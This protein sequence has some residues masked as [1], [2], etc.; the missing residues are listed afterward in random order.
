MGMDRRK[1]IISITVGALLRA[2][3]LAQAPHQLN[4][5]YLA[6]FPSVERVM[7]EIQG[8]DAHESALRQEAALR[9]L[10]QLLEDAA[11]P[12][13]FRNQ[14]TPDEQKL[15]GEYGFAQRRLAQQLNYPMGGYVADPKFR[16][17]IFEHFGLKRALA[18]AENADAYYKAKQDARTAQ[19]QQQGAPAAGAAGQPAWV[20]DPTRI[21][22]RRCLELGGGL[23]E[24]LGRGMKAGI[25]GLLG[26]DTNAV[27]HAVH[28]KGIRMIGAYRGSGATLTFMEDTV[29][30]DNCS[31][32]V[33]LFDGYSV[34]RVGNELAIRIANQPQPIAARLRLDGHILAPAAA[35]VTGKMVVGYQNVA[36]SKRYADGS[37]VPG[38]AHMERRPISQLRMQHC[39]IGTLQPG[40]AAPPDKDM[41]G[42]TTDAVSLVFSMLSGPE[43]QKEAATH[44]Q[45]VAPGPRLAGIYRSHDGLQ[46]EFHSAGAVIDC[47]E[48]H[49][50]ASYVVSNTPGGLVIN[51]HNGATPVTLTLQGDGSLL[52]SG[53]VT[54]NGRLVAGTSGSDVVFRPVSRSCA[55]G[56]LT[57]E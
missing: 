51:V 33:D 50:A 19:Q 13:L 47:K 11:G 37:M 40:Q 39:V 45:L 32:L 57:A 24:C 7:A 41:I 46:I 48:A 29:S 18:Q 54:V 5:L 36:V 6:E 2:V 20:N 53:E 27:G 15:D 38:S 34:E 44:M 42:S 30:I 43:K 21:A 26:V 10:K 35:D 14:L 56:T 16:Q 1:L 12:R 9:V 49:V 28:P 17:E 55:A 23:M 31:K 8:K 4:P 3:A 52:G 22:A 25:F